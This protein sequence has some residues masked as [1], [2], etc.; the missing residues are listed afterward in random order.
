[1]IKILIPENKGR[2]KTNIR[3]FW[4][5]KNT[6]KIYYDY[7]NILEYSDY[8]SYRHIENLRIKYN[9]ICIAI[10]GNAKTLNIYYQNRQDV[11]DNRIY[12][13]V[14]KENLRK[15]IKEALNNYSG[16]TIYQENKRYY[17]EIFYK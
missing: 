11:L 6:N 8:P 10:I 14:L 1:M 2:V 5:D 16:C 3:G 12:K 9:Q 13:E 15:E 4:I 7:I 17:I